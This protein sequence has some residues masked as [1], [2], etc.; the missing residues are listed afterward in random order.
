MIRELLT[1]H[2]PLSEREALLISPLR[3]AYIGDAVHDL[4]IR[5][6]LL[7][8]GGNVRAMHRN[9]VRAVNASAQAQTLGR[10]LPILTETENDVVRRGRNAH[11]NHDAP[12]RTDLADYSKATGF[13][14]LVGFLYMTGQMERLR[15]VCVVARDRAD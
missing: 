11:A 2:M 3:L 5:T 12:K 9:A 14:A 13:E 4:V 1:G 6:D 7:F 10:I 15:E 8:T